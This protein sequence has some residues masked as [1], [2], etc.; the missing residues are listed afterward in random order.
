KADSPETA[1][2]LVVRDLPSDTLAETIDWEER[3]NA[4]LCEF[5][6]MFDEVRATGRE[7]GTCCGHRAF[8]TTYT[9]R[10]KGAS[11]M[12]MQYLTT[13]TPLGEGFP[14]VY[15][16]KAESFT[17]PVPKGWKVEGWPRV[18]VKAMVLTMSDPSIPAYFYVN[19]E[20][21]P[22]ELDPAAKNWEAFLESVRRD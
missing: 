8:L 12:M 13:A 20:D 5:Q 21:P 3:F 10:D 7:E 18:S 16:H 1:F 15:E 4:I 19:V 14:S 2:N 9:C 6:K 17:I 11:I 22:K